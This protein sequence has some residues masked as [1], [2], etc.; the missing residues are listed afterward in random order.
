VRAVSTP[1]QTAWALLG[2]IA[3]GQGDGEALT[4]GVRHLVETQRPDGTWEEHLAT[5]TGFP[6]VFYLRYTLYRN[7]FPLLALSQARRA[8]EEAERTLRLVQDAAPTHPLR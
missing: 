8:I 6:N 1:S 7:Y 4:R 2:L 3:A 5:G